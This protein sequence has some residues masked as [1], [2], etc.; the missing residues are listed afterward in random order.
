MG[1]SI[2]YL[3]E[4]MQIVAGAGCKYGMEFHYGKFQLLDMHY[5]PDIRLPDNTCMM[6]ERERE[7]DR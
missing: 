7:R 3:T 5:N 1:V 4:Y 2:L 6:K